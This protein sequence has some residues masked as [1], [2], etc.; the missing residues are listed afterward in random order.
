MSHDVA[1]ELSGV[2][3]IFGNRATEALAEIRA[4][5]ISKK[6]VL[7]RFNCVVGVADATMDIRPGEIF[8]IMGLSGSG[9]STLVRHI[10]RLLEPTAGQI[11]VNGEDIMAMAPTRCASTATNI[12]PW[13]FRISR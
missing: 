9:K 1:I 4:S 10:N 6:E 12:S 5:D 7:D 13:C 3:K 11:V 8:C 2:W